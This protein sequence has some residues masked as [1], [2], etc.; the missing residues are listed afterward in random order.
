MTVASVAIYNK[1]SGL[2]FNSI[3]YPGAQASFINKFNTNILANDLTRIDPQIVILSFGTNEAS[4]DRLDLANYRNSYERIVDKIKTT[5]PGA[6]IVVIGP[7]DFAELP[8]ACRKGN[9]ASDLRPHGRGVCERRVAGRRVRLAYAGQAA[10]DPRSPA[11]HCA[12]SRARLLEL[13]LDHAAGMRR[14]SLV[15]G[16]AAAHGQGPRPFHDRG[17]QEER[18]SVP[19]HLDPRHRKGTA[20]IKCYFQQLS[21]RY[22]LLVVFPVTWLLN[23]H[24]TAKK[25]FL[26]AV[27]YVFYAFFRA[28]FTLILLAS[29]VMNFALALWLGSLADGPA[30]KAVLWLGIALNLCILAAFKY[31]NFFVASAMNAAHGIGWDLS[32]PF[33]E[34]GL[35]IAISF[36]TF[37]ALSYIID[38]YRHKLAPTRSLVDI[39]L[40]ISFFP[41]LVAGPIVR[42]KIFLEQT[43]RRSDPK[44]IRLAMSVFLIVGG[45]FKKVVVANYLSTDFV[46]GVFRSPTE[47]SRLDLLLGMYAYALQIYCDFSAYTDIAIGVANLLGYQFPQNFNQPYRATSVQD[48]WRRWHITLS[49]WLR[50]YLYIPLGGSRGRHL[51]HLPQHPDHHAARRPVARRELEFRDLGRPA[52]R[53]A[54]GRAPARRDGRARSP[55]PHP[56]SCCGGSSPCTSSA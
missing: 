46:D 31:Y 51:V 38:V 27:S 43:V 6:S 21:S 22:F 17:L 40:Y 44:D 34:V 11:R 20:R 26:V 23:N 47:Y 45:L 49:A 24:N 16:V 9:S 8:A 5:L 25:W 1:Q 36:L 4:N 10:S 33:F 48:F 18:R 7:P 39:L 15:L 29:S 19:H 3:G 55:Q 42:A 12:A 52:R 54:G 53:R 56:E 32:L 13:G 30:R 2:T 50:D 37:H 14:A 41:H 28:D 35:P